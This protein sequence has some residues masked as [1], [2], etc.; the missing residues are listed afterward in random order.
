MT[1]HRET[2]TLTLTLT[3]TLGGGMCGNERC[4]CE[5]SLVAAHWHS[6]APKELLI[7]EHELAN[8]SVA[9]AAAVLW[10]WLW[11][12]TRTVTAGQYSYSVMP[13]HCALCAYTNRVCIAIFIKLQVQ[14]QV[15]YIAVQYRKRCASAICTG[16]RTEAIQAEI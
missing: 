8:R 5:V 14:V 4:D 12:C 7:A 11:R 3:N 1:M 10:L 9:R 13:V 16:S 6:A 15:Q 2:V